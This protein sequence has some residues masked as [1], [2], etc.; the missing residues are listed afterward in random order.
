MHW[1]GAALLVVQFTSILEE[2]LLGDEHV[3]RLTGNVTDMDAFLSDKAMH[4]LEREH[5]GYFAFL[6]FHPSVDEAVHDY[7]REQSLPAD[8]GGSAL[9]LFTT[10]T[11]GVSMSMF[12]DQA[13]KMVE[14]GSHDDM[15]A[16]AALRHLFGAAATPAMPG[17]AV[18]SAFS[19]EVDVL[20]Y[21]LTGLNTAADVRTLAR[22]VFEVANK[23]WQEC[24]GRREV[25]AD[26]LALASTRRG[27]RFSHTGRRSMKEWLVLTLR[28]LGVHR[29]DLV[30]VAGLAIGA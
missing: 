26:R 7:V 2:A 16:Q 22:A 8:S 19:A 10:Q 5:G 30:A 24:E 6:A 23:A 4:A 14:V 9:V 11:A 15:P 28:W 17:L 21:P 29:G 20:Y 12:A 18:F 13:L 25:F 27:M 1:V 3:H